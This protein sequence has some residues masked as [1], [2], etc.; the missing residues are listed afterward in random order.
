M[1]TIT[2]TVKLIQVQWLPTLANISQCTFAKKLKSRH[3]IWDLEPTKDTMVKIW[4]NWCM[5]RSTDREPRTKS[6]GFQ[7]SEDTMD[8]RARTEHGKCNNLMHKWEMS[9]SPLYER[10][11]QQTIRYVVSINAH[12][13]RNMRNF[14]NQR[15]MQ[16]SGWRIWIY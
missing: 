5:E 6:P 16:C 12:N 7:A 1:R 8:N 9:E 2:G 4:K 15:R 14:I 11:M 10:G 13:I 3:F